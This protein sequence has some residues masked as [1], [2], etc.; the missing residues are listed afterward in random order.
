MQKRMEL[1]RRKYDSLE[2]GM[3]I[4]GEVKHF[5]FIELYEGVMGMMV[6]EHFGVMPEKFQAIK[7]PSE[8]RPQELLT[9]DDLAVNLGF[10]HFTQVATDEELESIVAQM[11]ELIV[12][13]NQ[14]VE[15]LGKEKRLTTNCQKIYYHFRFQGLDEAVY[16][17]QCLTL[18]DKRIM[19]GTFSCPYREQ[20][21]WG[22]AAVKMFGSVTDLTKPGAAQKI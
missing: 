8:F 21:E 11:M 3:Y 14:S 16:N 15:F 10:T 2:K 5:I 17:L 19:M 4:Q 18:V 22:S 12:R 7:Y 13:S 1:M 6:P 20:E 9:S